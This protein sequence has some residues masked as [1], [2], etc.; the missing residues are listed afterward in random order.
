MD[1]Q[2]IV[3]GARSRRPIGA[4]VPLQSLYGEAPGA[5]IDFV[6]IEP[7]RDRSE[8]FDWSIDAHTHAGLHQ[9]VLLFAGRFEVVLDEATHEITAPAVIAIPA[10]V[11]HSFEYE[12]HSSGFMLTI[13]DGLL[14]GSLIGAW[15]RSR[16]FETG[17]TLPLDGDENLVRRLRILSS[18]IVN[19]QVTVDSARLATIDWLTRTVLVL[20]ARESE[21][22][23]QSRPEYQTS[24]LL[25]DFRSAVEAHFIEHWPVG[26][27]AQQL[28][29]SESSLNRLCQAV[30][31]MTAFEIVQDRL[32]LE[33]R[34]R[35]IY[36]TVPVHRL[37]ADLGFSDPSY[38]AR[39]LKRRTGFSPRAFRAQHSPVATTR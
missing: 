30:A 13:A 26:R 7:L 38:F 17:I 4:L 2:A 27:Y 5:V 15:L 6:H 19:E 35:L 9:V 28:H 16:L 1:A 10:S 34:R 23:H 20:L 14:D 22:V 24:D 3:G 37:A 36:T 33:A 31:A 21:R 39:F 18:E 8:L 25:R 11:V 32:E 29:V 12:P